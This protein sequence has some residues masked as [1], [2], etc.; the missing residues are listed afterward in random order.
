MT[1]SLE[2]DAP[3]PDRV[4]TVPNL[5]SLL[6]LLGVPLFLWLALGPHADG[7]ALG[8]LAFGGVSGYPG[9]QIPRPVNPS[10]PLGALPRPPAGPPYNLPPTLPPTAPGLRPP[11]LPRVDP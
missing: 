3:A 10:S 6:R 2:H 5:L 7:W 8:V 1:A 9:G 4:W 11:W